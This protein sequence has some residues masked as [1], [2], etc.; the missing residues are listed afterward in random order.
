VLQAVTPPTRRTLSPIWRTGA[1]AP[2]LLALLLAGCATSAPPP[3]KAEGPRADGCLQSVSLEKLEQAIRRCDAVVAA[4]PRLPQ[5]RN[6]RALLLS[7]AGRN[8]EACRDSAA[9]A[10]L[11]ARLPRQPA[12][13]PLL[14][15]EI[16]FRQES[17]RNWQRSL[18]GALTTPPAADAPSAAAPGA[19][20]R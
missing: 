16:R 4:H 17:C 10:Q 20:T 18:P 7:L 6:E 5:P 12:P 1:Q 2:L 8:L 9:A 3:D 11:L 19:P 14:V 13:D 15:E